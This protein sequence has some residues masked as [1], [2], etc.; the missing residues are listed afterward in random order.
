MIKGF[1]KV[2]YK[3]FFTLA[4]HRRTRGHAFKLCKSRSRLDVRKYFFS[5]R[6]VETWNKLPKDV[7]NAEIGRASCR[8]RV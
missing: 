6:I 5:Q 2:D 7:V 4:E 3:K 8:E 1:S